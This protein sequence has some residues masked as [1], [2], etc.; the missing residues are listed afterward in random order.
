MNF[1]ATAR[2]R[3]NGDTSSGQ[4]HSLFHTRETYTRPRTSPCADQFRLKPDPIVADEQ[5]ESPVTDL[6][7]NLHSSGFRNFRRT[8]Y[9]EPLE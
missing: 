3:M 2:G 4:T 6:E 9:V 7:T 8:T 1:S 5:I